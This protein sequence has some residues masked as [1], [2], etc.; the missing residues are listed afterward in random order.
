MAVEINGKVYRNL[1]EQVKKNQEDIESLGS[2]SLKGGEG[3]DT[4]VQKVENPY[5]EEPAPAENEATIGWAVAFGKSNKSTNYAA[6]TTGTRN[7][8]N[9]DS[10]LVAGV[11]NEVSAS[12]FASFTVGRGN[13][14]NSESSI[15]G[16]YY[17][18]S[19]SNVGENLVVGTLLQANN[20]NQHII[21]TANELKTGLRFAVGN[22]T[23]GIDP[24]TYEPINIVRKNALEVYKSGNVEIPDG[25]LSVSNGS[26][27]AND[28]ITT[29]GKVIA[30]G[31][32][33][34]MLNEKMLDCSGT[35]IIAEK[36]ISCRGALKDSANYTRLT[37]D[38]TS[39]LNA[40]LVP[41]ASNTRQ[42]GGAGAQWKELWVRD[43][44]NINN[45]SVSVDDLAALIAYAKAQ[46][47]IS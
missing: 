44:K 36:D 7:E 25:N 17:N 6:F 45:K 1:P 35:F 24:E 29:N 33:A 3:P 15:V 28:T 8:N 4:V 38:A 19:A 20:D 31:G 21:G 32:F 13:E 40:S 11:D 47:W 34:N 12:G 43:I 26:L 14:N 46:G 9:G 37:L 30:L 5:E 42:L 16:G 18:T 10:A 39:T 2:T 22:G 27:F 41:N 23:Y